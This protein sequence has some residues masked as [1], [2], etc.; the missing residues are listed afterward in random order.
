MLT[1]EFEDYYFTTVFTPKA[2]DGLKD[3][4]KDKNGTSS[5]PTT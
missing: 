2:G 4:Q 3:Q 1:I 5:M